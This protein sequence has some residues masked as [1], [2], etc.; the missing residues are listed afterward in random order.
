MCLVYII[1]TIN[2]NY[3]T[4]L[5]VAGPIWMS[6]SCL[7]YKWLNCPS[8]L[9][10]SKVHIGICVPW[11]TYKKCLAFLAFFLTD[12]G[13][14]LS[15]FFRQI[16]VEEV[17]KEEGPKPTISHALTKIHTSLDRNIMMMMMTKKEASQFSLYQ[18]YIMWYLYPHLARCGKVK[19]ILLNLLREG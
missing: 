4:H 19:I 11:S 9:V 3:L 7:V 8:Y 12:D 14:F 13:P 16:P 17:E 15:A 5:I 2:C 10:V 18:Q 1:C 6:A